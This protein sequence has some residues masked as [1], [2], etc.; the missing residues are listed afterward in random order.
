MTI[1]IL[2][3][4]IISLAATM[5]VLTVCGATTWIVID[6]SIPIK[7]GK[8][9]VPALY[10]VAGGFLLIFVALTKTVWD[11]ALSDFRRKTP[12]EILF[13]QTLFLQPF[14]DIVKRAKGGIIQGKL[15]GIRHDNVYQRPHF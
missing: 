13:G 4:F 14:L 6:R 5:L 9:S 12:Y 11:V 7:V 1:R 3:N 15:F 8:L 2:G 10:L